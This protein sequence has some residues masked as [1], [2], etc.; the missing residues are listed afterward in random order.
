M[1][2]GVVSSESRDGFVRVHWVHTPSARRG[3]THKAKREEVSRAETRRFLGVRGSAPILKTP[4][5]HVSY[6]SVL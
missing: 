3:R 2:A 1:V 5:L 6:P 4:C